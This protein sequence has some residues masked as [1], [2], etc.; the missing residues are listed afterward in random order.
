MWTKKF[1]LDA[2]ERALKT[3][4]QVVVLY[5][6]AAGPFDAF[7]FAWLTALGLGLG[8]VALS[9]LTS[10]ASSGVG[11]DPTSASLVDKV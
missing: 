1:W 3:G 5:A 2:L 8:G 9:V 11:D 4:A 10:L 7:H 6:T